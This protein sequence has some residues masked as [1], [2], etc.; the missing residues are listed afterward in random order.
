MPALEKSPA[1]VLVVDGDARCRDALAALLRRAGYRT[2][3]FDR[4]EALLDSL[5]P[6]DPPDCVISEL[7]LPG[8]D[9]LALSRSLR[10][11][12]LAVPV[13]ILTADTDVGTAVRA[14]RGDVA[15]YLLKPYVDRELVRRL[16][17]ALT[18]RPATLN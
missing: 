6:G 5:G 16:R 17:A 11:R 9:G 1:T 15:D 7:R 18:R 14:L 2:R 10:D 13:I 4:A 3:D 12:A 8:M